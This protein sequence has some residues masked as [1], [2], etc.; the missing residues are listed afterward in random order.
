MTIKIIPISPEYRE[1][2]EKTFGKNLPDL[3]KRV[4]I[5]DALNK[6]DGEVNQKVRYLFPRENRQ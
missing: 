3:S 2:W 5:S 4:D 6:V 1:G